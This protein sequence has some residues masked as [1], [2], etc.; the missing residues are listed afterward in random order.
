MDK[1]MGDYGNKTAFPDTKSWNSFVGLIQG[2]IP[3]KILK[4]NF[5]F[6]AQRKRSLHL[7]ETSEIRSCIYDF[8][9]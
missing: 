7:V 8:N 9:Y 4:T 6:H 1:I 3:R 2:H 5:P